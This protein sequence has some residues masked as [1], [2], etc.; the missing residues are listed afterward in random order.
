[1]HE[2][3][4]VPR[5]TAPRSKFYGVVALKSALMARYIC[6]ICTK[7]SCSALGTHWHQA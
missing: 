6:N 5:G 2:N 3:V 1:M 4:S 7:L